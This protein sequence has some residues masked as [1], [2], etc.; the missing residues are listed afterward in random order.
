MPTS[1]LLAPVLF[2]RSRWNFKY[3]YLKVCARDSVNGNTVVLTVTVIVTETRKFR[4]EFP[5]F[6]RRKMISPCE[7]LNSVRTELIFQKTDVLCTYKKAVFKCA[8]RSAAYDRHKTPIT[9]ANKCLT[10]EHINL[11]IPHGCHQKQSRI[12]FGW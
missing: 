3:S 6:C 4:V 10:K 7:N 8:R 9:D 11:N 1:A 2:N 12:K 5:T